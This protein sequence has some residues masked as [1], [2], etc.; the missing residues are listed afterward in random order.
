MAPSY[1]AT[2]DGKP[3]KFQSV[4][5]YSHGGQA[6]KL[7]LTDKIKNCEQVRKLNQGG[8]MLISTGRQKSKREFSATIANVM[9]PKGKRA[10]QLSTPRLDGVPSG[11]SRKEP[12]PLTMK[13]ED[14]KS[15]VTFSI[16]SP[17]VL[18]ASEV[19]K[20][21]QDV[22]VEFPTELR[23]LGCGAIPRSDKLKTR[24]QPDLKLKINQTAFAIR[25]ATLE[26]T[27]EHYRSSGMGH[28]TLKLSTEGHDCQNQAGSDITLDFGLEP[29]KTHSSHFTLNGELTFNRNMQTQIESELKKLTVKTPSFSDNSRPTELAGSLTLFGFEVELSGKL[30]PEICPSR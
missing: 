17:I 15:L 3:V 11:G 12:S 8:L 23:A 7:L 19:F 25:G 21:P 26:E 9:L 28:Y 18:G 27:P 13:K 29:G 10:W 14:P 5:A 30:T 24:A 1:T 6:L 16:Q 22:K 4:F 2:I 20:R